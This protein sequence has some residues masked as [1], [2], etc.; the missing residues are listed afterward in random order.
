MSSAA[1]KYDVPR[2]LSGILLASLSVLLTLIS[3]WPFAAL[4]STSGAY[5]LLTIA[6]YGT[7][8]FASSYVEEEQHIWYWLTSGWLGLLR[9]LP[10]HRKTNHSIQLP[11]LVLLILH[12]IIQRWNQTG[13]K[14]AGAPDIVHDALLSSPS[15]L[16]TLVLATYASLTIRL[17]RHFALDMRAGGVVGTSCAL[18]QALQT[19]LFKLS[20]TASDAPELVSSSFGPSAL[21]FLR[22]IPLLRIARFV[23][24][25]LALEAIWAF[26][27]RRTKRISGPNLISTLH[28][29]LTL[30]LITQTR[31]HNIPLFLLFLIQFFAL[32][33]LHLSPTQISL[34][35]LL[36]AQTS[37]FALGNSNSISSIDLGNAYNGVSGYNVLAVGM[38]VFVGNWAGPI[39]WSV[40]GIVLLVEN[41]RPG[42]SAALEDQETKGQTGNGP[43]SSATAAAAETNSANDKAKKPVHN[44][45][46]W[47]SQEHIHLA[48]TASPSAQSS[49]QPLPS[50]APSTALSTEKAFTAH[51]SLHTLFTSAALLFVMASCTILR[52]HLFIWTVFSPKYLY[53][54]AWNLGFHLLISVG[55]GWGL[56]R[57]GM[58]ED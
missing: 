46:H 31:V 7:M 55:L 32:R 56:W 20:F 30:L 15:L 3:E 4:H 1:S 28:T 14:H 25:T 9:L 26:L 38:L 5:F 51:L 43:S 57:V 29:L 12:R 39:W 22:E 45:R 10:S 49:L 21:I 19:V 23:F 17:A 37:F 24:G 33:R 40:A 58:A 8:M 47:I 34:T 53:A 41:A 36:L 13:Q 16:W 54:M 52:Q 44:R 11:I 35:T 6:L 18:M 42:S 48:A 50:S 27:S 2:L